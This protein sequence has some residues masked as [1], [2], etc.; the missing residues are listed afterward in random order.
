MLGEILSADPTVAVILI[1]GYPSIPSAIEATKRGVYQY[2]EKPVDRDRLLEVVGS[3]FEHLAAL[4][5]NILGDSPA[6]RAMVRMILKVAPTQHTV[7][8]LGE[9]GTGK[10]LVAR[11]IHRHSPRKDQP[12]LAVNCA[13]LTETLLESELFGH[14]KGAFTGAVAAKPGKF[15]L[16][17]KGT[18][19]LDE[20]GDLS[21][22]V[23]LKILRVIQE[24]EF[25]RLGGTAT[26]KADIRLLAATHRDLEQAVANGLFREDLYY[27]LNVVPL[28]LPPLRERMEDIP[29]LVRHFLRKA[30]DEGLP[31]KRLENDAF[32]LL[33]RYRW[34]GNVRELRNL[35]ERMLIM[36][37]G[38]RIEVRHLPPNLHRD[39]HRAAS[40]HAG[41]GGFSSLHEARAAY[42]R[43]YIL[44]KLDENHGNVS[45]TAEVLGL[46]RSHLYR[47]MKALGISVRE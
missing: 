17:D 20:I 16:A 19:F 32:D 22:N 25:T 8:I 46:E 41:S 34:P 29:D 31:A 4:K 45:R 23:Q 15:E 9:S 30:V 44:R 38:E 28:R 13:A 35:V 37:S 43:D 14:E 6:T 36:V 1:T 24:R 12:F 21:P 7:L 18:I 10:E 2:L 40:A 3:V 5:Q 47:K 27:R 26:L 39:T 11:E 42:E 33:K